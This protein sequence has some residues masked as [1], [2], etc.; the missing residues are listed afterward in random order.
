[1]KVTSAAFENNTQTPAQFT[2]D[3]QNI[4]PSLTLTVLPQ[5]TQSLTLIVDDLDALGGTWDHWL[6]ANLQPDSQIAEN[7]TPA[8]AVV[9]K[10]SFGK[11]EYDGPC[12]PSGTHHYRFTVY[13]LDTVLDL[14]TGFG[15]KDLEQA[16]QSHVLDQAQLVGLYR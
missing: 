1:M 5:E 13:A 7:T 4:N 15:K 16:M 10:N 8:G 11:V 6:L 12:P 14:P 3:G 2:C 9:G